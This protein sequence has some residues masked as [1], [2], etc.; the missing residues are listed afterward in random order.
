MR[1]E[2]NKLGPVDEL[3]FDINEKDFVVFTGPQ[4]SGKST[5]AKVVYFCLNMRNLIAKWMCGLLSDSADND[6]MYAVTGNWR[7]QNRVH[8]TSESS[9]KEILK[10]VID[11]I[12][13][14]F[15][16]IFALSYVT[17]TDVRYYYRQD[18]CVDIHI[19]KDSR[20]FSVR[21][22]KYLEDFIADEVRKTLSRTLQPTDILKQVYSD[23]CSFFDDGIKGVI[24][25][26]AGRGFLT[27]LSTNFD[28]I[29][30][31]M[32]DKQKNRI[33]FC[34]QQYIET[35]MAARS[36]FSDGIAKM[37]VDDRVKDLYSKILKGDYRYESNHERIYI[38]DE[39]YESINV[40]SSGQQEAVW[41]LNILLHEMLN[42]GTLFIIEEPE[43]HLYPDAQKWITQFIS[44]ARHNRE[45]R[46]LITTHSPYILGEIN[47]LLYADKIKDS[48][49][50]RAQLDEAVNKEERIAFDSMA[51]Y[52][53]DG[54]K[55]TSCTD[56]EFMSIKNEVIDG[57]SVAINEEFDAML[58]M[59]GNG[60]EE[61]GESTNA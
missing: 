30:G 32:T 31:S 52:F 40:A 25:I 47:N 54:G 58:Q 14:N 13:W 12:R 37:V 46:V 56:D 35:V 11:A 38:N 50:D 24:Y 34:T 33:D 51:A 45:N 21:L 1:I 23:V 49:T 44:L 16:Q 55:C 9:N 15:S 3:D 18:V 48:V 27:L 41:V 5:T 59:T 2:I 39:Q 6:N 57:A 60:E 22:G 17:Q 10:D 43:A 19:E 20:I 53:F 42:K 36:D 7:E 28:W 4:A 29:Y 26:P 61:Q 8:L